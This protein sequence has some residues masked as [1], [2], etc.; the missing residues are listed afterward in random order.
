MFESTVTF[1]YGITVTTSSLMIAA[2]AWSAARGPFTCLDL[3]AHR[4]MHGTLVAMTGAVRSAVENI[5]F[6]V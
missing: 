4:K 2:G 3:L 6:E 1:A 5:P